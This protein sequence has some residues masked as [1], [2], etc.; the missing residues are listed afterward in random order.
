[1]NTSLK[2]AS[3]NIIN[4]L[5]GFLQQLPDQLYTTPLPLL[6]DNTIGKH[7]RHIVEFYECTFSGTNTGTV[8]Y[9]LRLR[10][11]H[12]ETD[13][14]CCI[15]KLQHITGLIRAV[16]EDTYLNLQMS[17]ATSEAP[18]QTGTSL[19]RELVYNIEHAVHHMAIIRMAIRSANFPVELPDSFGVAFSTIQ[20]QASAPAN[21]R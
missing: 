5:I 19:Y 11:V 2:I 10:N 4:Q 20:Y 16:N 7:I 15:E 18:L 13:K 17:M 21:F 8:N 1:M 9:D 3:E 14:V 12:L 6:S